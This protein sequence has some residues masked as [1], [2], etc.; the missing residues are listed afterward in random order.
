MSQTPFSRRQALTAFASLLSA[1]PL[2]RA[3]EEPQ[4]VGEA[5]DRFTPVGEFANALEYEPM[6]QRKLNQETFAAIA[7]GDHTAFDRITF[8]P[9]LMVN[10]TALDLTVDLF[11]DPHFSPILIGPAAHQ[12]RFHPEGE[13]AMARG[14]AAGKGTMVVADQ[15]DYPIAKLA[16]QANVNL[17]YQI[18][19]EADSTAAVARIRTAA[20]AGCK[21][22]CL[23]VGTTANTALDWDYVDRVRQRVDL[24]LL[25]KGIMHG[26]EA[27]LAADRG[28]DGI[29]VSNHGRSLSR[30][31][32]D[33]IT[34]LPSI[35]A[36][37][38]GKIPILLDG[39]VRRGSDV[40]KALALGA[41]AV[42][43]ARPALWALAAYGAEGV[44]SLVEMLQT[45]L[46]RDMTML[47]TVNPAAA[48]KNHVRIHRR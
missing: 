45:E 27:R 19:P 38:A 31:L 14:A 7:D 28:I 32:A 2:L 23:T 39:G 21:A 44:Q 37:V 9:R 6:A 22:V 11:G 43:I 48:S 1:S 26:D 8:R 42:L 3:Q 29:V 18:Y 20:S 47:G 24:P 17:W 5:P 25:L 41:R 33:P 15:S 34:V 35:S 13:L 16:D 12:L 30:G 4:L 46:G 10:T 40:L 36:A